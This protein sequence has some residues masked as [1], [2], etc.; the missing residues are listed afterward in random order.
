MAYPLIIIFT[1]HSHVDFVF[2]KICLDRNKES[3]VEEDNLAAKNEMVKAKGKGKEEKENKSKMSK[4]GV[5]DTDSDD[6]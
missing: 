4:N 6:E 3:S 2:I 1:T 5:F